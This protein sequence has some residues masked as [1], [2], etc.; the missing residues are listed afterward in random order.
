MK[1]IPV[2]MGITKENFSKERALMEKNIEIKI[3]KTAKMILISKRKTINSLKSTI[4]V[5]S[6]LSFIIAAPKTLKTAYKTE[7]NIIFILIM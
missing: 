2:K 5:L 6:N 7:K 3:K 1:L 4:A